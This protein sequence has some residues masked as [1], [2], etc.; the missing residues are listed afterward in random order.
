MGN[1]APDFLPLG[2][3][4]FMSRVFRSLGARFMRVTLDYIHILN[5]KFSSF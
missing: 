4:F 3:S 2:Y 5:K 1:F